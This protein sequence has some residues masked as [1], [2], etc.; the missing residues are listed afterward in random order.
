MTDRYRRKAIVDIRASHPCQ[1]LVPQPGQR[2]NR[3]DHAESRAV[4]ERRRAQP[5]VHDRGEDRQHCPLDDAVRDRRHLQPAR[6]C[7]RTP[8]GE[9]RET[10]RPV[11]PGQHPVGELAQVVLG[12]IG[13]ARHP[14]AEHT[15]I[16]VVGQHV[17]P[18]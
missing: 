6:S 4:R 9:P 1:A 3:V 16:A 12:V 8:D 2:L 17:Q 13:E 10:T 18:R 14:S 7:P 15:V 11:R 5:G